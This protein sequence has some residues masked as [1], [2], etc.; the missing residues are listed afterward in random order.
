MELYFDQRRWRFSEYLNNQEVQILKRFDD[1]TSFEQDAKQNSHISIYKTVKAKD[2]EIGDILFI[3]KNEILAADVILLE[4]SDSSCCLNSSFNEGLTTQKKAIP[5]SITYI[6]KSSKIKGHHFDYKKILNGIIEYVSADV[7]DKTKFEGFMKLSKDPQGIII[8]SQNIGYRGSVL[9][10][11]E[12]ALGIVIYCGHD[13]YYYKKDSQK[14]LKKPSFFSKKSGKLFAISIF[15]YLFAAFVSV[16]NYFTNSCFPDL[17]QLNS[18]GKEFRNKST[19][20]IGV[21]YMYD[22]ILFLPQFYY[23]VN[24]LKTLI[25][26]VLQNRYYEKNKS[27]KE[28]NEEK[29]ELDQ[30]VQE[31][32]EEDEESLT[33]KQSAQSEIQQKVD[34]IIKENAESSYDKPISPTNNIPPIE[35]IPSLKDLK[36]SQEL[37]KNKS[38]DISQK[39]YIYSVNSSKPLADLTLT[40]HCFLDKTGTLTQGRSFMV[41]KLYLEECSYFI[42]ENYV[43]PL[44]KSVNGAHIHSG[45]NIQIDDNKIS[46]ENDRQIGNLLGFK[47]QPSQKVEVQP[48]IF[49]NNQIS[50]RGSILNTN[51]NIYTTMYTDNQNDIV[52]EEGVFL[53]QKLRSQKEKKKKIDLE[54][55]KYCEQQMQSPKNLFQKSPR[56]S[57]QSFQLDT[58]NLIARE[59]ISFAFNEEECQNELNVPNLI[60]IKKSSQQSI[61]SSNQIKSQA[62]IQANS[63]TEVKQNQKKVRKISFA[64]NLPL[65]IDTY[66]ANSELNTV[67][68][69][70]E[71]FKNLKHPEIQINLFD[72]DKVSNQNNSFQHISSPHSRQSPVPDL[73][74]DIINSFRVNTQN[75]NNI[76]TIS[77]TSYASSQVK[78]NNNN[79][80]SP[81]TSNNSLLLNRFRKVTNEI[82]QSSCNTDKSDFFTSSKLAGIQTSND[83]I[84]PLRKIN[85]RYA[86]DSV[87]PQKDEQ[88]L[89]EELRSEIVKFVPQ[90]EAIIALTICHVS[91]SVLHDEISQLITDHQSIYDEL[92]VEFS[93]R[94]DCRLKCIAKGA[95]HLEYIFKLNKEIHIYEVVVPPVYNQRGTRLAI[96]VR[97]F[98][99]YFLYTREELVNVPFYLKSIRNLKERMEKHL[100]Y[101]IENGQVG[102]L[103]CKKQLTELQAA[104]IIE[105][106]ISIEKGLNFLE[107]E[108]QIEALYREQL[109]NMDMLTLVSLKENLNPNAK[110]LIENLRQ[111]NINTWLLTGDDYQRALATSYETGMLQK[112]SKNDI[113]HF[114]SETEEETINLMKS[115][116]KTIRELLDSDRTDQKA[117]SISRKYQNTTLQRVYNRMLSFQSQ[118]LKVSNISQSKGMNNQKNPN[119]VQVCVIVNGQ[120]LE[121]ILNNQYLKDHFSFICF[122]CESLIGYS[123]KPSQKAELVS[124]VKNVKR[125]STFTLAIGDGLNDLQMMQ[126]ADFSIQYQNQNLKSVQFEHGLAQITVSQLGAISKL[127]FSQSRHEAELFEETL[128]FTFYRSF[129]IF[130]VVFFWNFM[131]CSYGDIVLSFLDLILIHFISLFFQSVL[132][133]IRKYQMLYENKYDSFTVIQQY[134]HN[135]FYFQDVFKKF[136]LHLIPQSFIDAFI[137]FILMY[138]MK[139]TPME[140]N[141]RQI[142]KEQLILITVMI[143]YFLVHI[144]VMIIL[145]QS[146]KT[147][148]ANLAFPFILLCIYMGVYYEAQDVSFYFSHLTIL[149]IAAIVLNFIVT[150]F[151]FR[152]F[153]PLIEVG[154]MRDTKIFKKIFKQIENQYQKLLQTLPVNIFSKQQQQYLS[155]SQVLQN[156]NNNSYSNNQQINREQNSNYSNLNAFQ[157]NQLTIG[158]F[159]DNKSNKL[160]EEQQTEQDNQSK[161]NTNER[162]VDNQIFH[163]ANYFISEQTSN[164]NA[165]NL[166]NKVIKQNANKYIDKLGL[167]D[168]EY[169]NLQNKTVLRNRQISITKNV[170]LKELHNSKI[171]TNSNQGNQSVNIQNE[172]NIPSNPSTDR[173]LGKPQQQQNQENINKNKVEARRKMKFKGYTFDQIFKMVFKDNEID[174]ILQDL[175]TE[176][177]SVISS[178]IDKV[179]LHFPSKEIELKFAQSIIQQWFR[180]FRISTI[181]LSLICELALSQIMN[182]LYQDQFGFNLYSVSFGLFLLTW[183]FMFTPYYTRFFFKVNQILLIIRILTRLTYIVFDSGHPFDNLQTM[184]YCQILQYSVKITPPVFFSLQFAVSI[185]FCLKFL[186]IYDDYQV[187]NS[188][189]NY[190]KIYLI[191]TTFI[192]I[193]AF[194]ILCFYKKYEYDFIERKNFQRI[195][196]ISIETKKINNVLSILLPKFILDSIDEKGREFQEDQGDVAILFCDICDFDLIIQEEQ[197]NIIKLLDKLFRFYDNACSINGIQKIETVGKTYMAAAGIKGIKYD[198]SQK[199]FNIFHPVIRCILMANQMFEASRKITYSKQ[200]KQIGIK[201]GIHYGPVLAGVIGGHK[202]QFSLI[203]DTVNMASR[204]CSTGEANFITLSEQAKE[205]CQFELQILNEKRFHQQNG[206]QIVLFERTV[207]AKGK[208]NIKTYQVKF[209]KYK[210]KEIHLLRK[211]SEKL[212]QQRNS[213]Q[214]INNENSSSDSYSSPYYNMASP[215]KKNYSIF[216]PEANHGTSIAALDYS[217]QG[218]IK[219]ET[220]I[221]SS[222]VISTFNNTSKSK[223]NIYIEEQVYHNKYLYSNNP[224]D[225]QDIQEI[226]SNSVSSNAQ[227]IFE[228]N[229]KQLAY[230]KII[231]DLVEEIQIVPQLEHAP[232]LKDQELDIEKV[233]SHFQELKNEAISLTN[234]QHKIN[235]KVNIQDIILGKYNLDLQ[236]FYDTELQKSYQMVKSKNAFLCGFEIFKMLIANLMRDYLSNEGV[237]I[238]FFMHMASALLLLSTIFGINYITRIG[239]KYLKFIIF[240][241]YSTVITSIVFEGYLNIKYFP[242]RQL[243]NLQTAAVIIIFYVFLSFKFFTIQEKTFISLC[244]IL[245]YYMFTYVNNIFEWEYCYL[246]SAIILNI[247][248]RSFM[249]LELDFSSYL[250]TKSLDQKMNDQN[251]LLEYLLPKHIRDQFLEN[252]SKQIN[253]IDKFDQVTIL[254]ADIAGFTKYSASVQP[255]QVFFMLRELFTKFDQKC[256]ENN[257][258]KLYTIGDCYVVMGLVNLNDRNTVK[259][260]MNVIGMG[261][262]MIEIIKQV[263]SIV[264]FDELDMR[265]GIHTG[266]IIGGVVGTG[267]VRYDIYGPDVVIANKME[268]NG[269]SGRVMVSEATYN[270]VHEAS[271]GVYEFE[272]PQIIQL[273]SDKD[274]DKDKDKNKDK[275]KDKDEDEDEDE[276]EGKDKDKDK[277]KNKN[278][279]IKAYFVKRPIDNEFDYFSS[280][281][282]S[283]FNAYQNRTQQFQM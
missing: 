240:I 90:R 60:S 167:D 149:L 218:E 231:K 165:N 63:Q 43:D 126:R 85:K 147:F 257:V 250:H 66:K 106:Y 75:Y 62:N 96:L 31:I 192:C 29:Q 223:E 111:A 122:F 139:S 13:C 67:E 24:D 45:K 17:P 191:F 254:Y 209:K 177:V 217:R 201:I 87:I 230:I 132:Y 200:Q 186:I 164:L 97:I 184:F 185:S 30:Q 103:F 128:F 54:N 93:K 121:K 23:F 262:E 247:L 180:F 264:N 194:Q 238:T 86:V 37:N 77:E 120:C 278:K 256:Q 3:R 74:K 118:S 130:F 259:E 205:S 178:K 181:I 206:F 274:K 56:R 195:N 237:Y 229:Q 64:Q 129:F 263:R 61:K 208:G 163:K 1:Q 91:K 44:F 2:V 68:N 158:A 42:S 19:G 282:D 32:K 159:N 133:F 5:P 89:Y 232:I 119:A 18:E 41:H 142:E 153:I 108:K 26:A 117:T 98:K 154:M 137:L 113:F 179:F 145:S 222:N 101:M 265:I 272:N 140:L 70:P 189:D 203:G 199:K 58:K 267:V 36:Q 161:K 226:R 27:Q 109:S 104:Q 258:Y 65:S 252:Q 143:F 138:Q 187:S 150:N 210:K 53:R 220:E 55:I 76:D 99:N 34:F 94:F 162:T 51:P 273:S 136:L 242:N 251:K 275:D 9:E 22:Y 156:E 114:Q 241:I 125:D 11:A 148:I 81:Q 112:F 146:R 204:V 193:L 49:I 224:K 160:T 4:M 40:T 12:W 213:V 190:L 269:E 270:L 157:L 25:F 239:L 246:T 202:P 107:K 88:R 182:Y 20:R 83:S 197:S 110:S 271:T 176:N 39:P 38:K 261:F 248:Y 127:I 92:F 235:S 151:F 116:L 233:R 95:N 16:I 152:T 171:E 266:S 183:G 173:K 46:N 28:E 10:Y 168:I 245:N 281:N 59:Q 50:H 255:E 175:N 100:K 249:Q 215:N 135:K 14:R 198:E 47:I 73:N 227:S 80:Q 196:K 134:F 212:L 141:G 172:Q 52:G 188:D 79:N 170:N 280:Q 219:E 276:D 105:K 155:E 72:Q 279:T 211:F 33:N 277:D 57:R 8:T 268:S 7:R 123:L 228:A 225:L 207:N 243:I 78:Y 169:D 244:L 216:S 253:L 21:S 144:K 166:K 69:N 102:V 260:A 221:N 48:S 84:S 131:S 236:L 234:Q 283:N 174:Q 82:L 214:M 15:F 115:N 35:K 71:S 6:S 124:L